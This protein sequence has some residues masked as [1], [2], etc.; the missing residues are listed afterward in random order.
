MGRHLS[1]GR[2]LRPPG[3][4]DRPPDPQDL[5]Q[6]KP[7]VG[8]NSRLNGDRYGGRGAGAAHPFRPGRARSSSPQHRQMRVCGSHLRAS[9]LRRQLEAVNEL[10]D[11]VRRCC[12]AAIPTGR[13]RVHQRNRWADN[14]IR[15]MK[16]WPTSPPSFGGRHRHHEHLLVSA[17]ER[18]RGSASAGLN[19][20][21]HIS[22]SCDRDWCSAW[23]ANIGIF[24]GMGF[25]LGIAPS[26][27][28]VARP[29]PAS[30]RWAPSGATSAA[31]W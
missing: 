14:T 16:W 18:T 5:F 28:S 31:W 8:E 21:R 10:A 24:A 27:T 3:L 22:S 19:K 13:I 23:P 25:G 20:P 9:P 7:A 17:A 30:S 12:A 4:C 15:I 26:S 11:A 1:E 29:S 2:A 6:D